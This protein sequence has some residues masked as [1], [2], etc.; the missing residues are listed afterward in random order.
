VT[1]KSSEVNKFSFNRNRQRKVTVHK[2]RMPIVRCIC[3]S[4]ILVVPD[5]KAMNIAVDNHVT[6]KH[7]ITSDDSQ[8]LSEFLV[9]QV[10]LVATKINKSTLE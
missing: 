2:R 6:T 3:G 10:I 8:M 4:E 7:K 1:K 9:E 5:L